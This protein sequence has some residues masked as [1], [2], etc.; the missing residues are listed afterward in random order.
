MLAG[1]ACWACLKLELT[2]IV[3]R[4]GE[5]FKIVQNCS[6]ALLAMRRFAF[7]ALASTFFRTSR[8]QYPE[9]Y[10][11]ISMSAKDR[12]LIAYTAAIRLTPATHQ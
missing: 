5:L 6:K 3:A 7:N 4:V 2:D 11:F 8:I 9:T 1:H 10:L 12:A